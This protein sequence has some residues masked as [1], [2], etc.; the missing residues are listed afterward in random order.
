MD[1]K[2]KQF[3]SE[4]LPFDIALRSFEDF[5]NNYISKPKEKFCDCNTDIACTSEE[6]GFGNPF[7]Y[8]WKCKLAR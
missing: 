7:K 4:P 8:C 5:E 2:F 6:D 3:C 1:F